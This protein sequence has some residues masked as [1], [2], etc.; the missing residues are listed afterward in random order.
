MFRQVDIELNQRLITVSVDSYY[1]Y[2]AY[3][4]AV[5]NTNIEDTK[6]ILKNKLFHK[7]SYDAMD[8]DSTSNIGF[9]RRYKRTN[10]ANTV[11]LEC[12]IRMDICQQKRF[13][14]NGIQIQM[15]LYQHEDPFQLIAESADDYNVEIQYT[16]ES[17]SGETKPCYGGN[18]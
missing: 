4:D 1:P 13:I 16:S 6:G 17:L 18:A 9:D 7:D 11:F 3:L 12:P 2:K 8:S 14:V 10:K 15:K 5:L